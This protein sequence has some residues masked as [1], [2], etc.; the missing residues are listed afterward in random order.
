MTIVCTN[1]H[2]R[3]DARP[4]GICVECGLSMTPKPKDTRQTGYMKQEV[5]PKEEKDG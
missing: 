3:E 5:K 4:R 2:E 1:G